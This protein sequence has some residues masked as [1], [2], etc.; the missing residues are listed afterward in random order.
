MNDDVEVHVLR[1][2]EAWT[3]LASAVVPECGFCRFMKAGPCGAEFKAPT[4]CVPLPR[5][6]LNLLPT[7]PLEFD[8]FMLGCLGHERFALS[9]RRGRT[10]SNARGK[11]MPISSSYAAPRRF[12]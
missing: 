3:V 5:T 4:A 7:A 2:A 9:R 1:G 10:A 12:G 8:K 6:H 11:P